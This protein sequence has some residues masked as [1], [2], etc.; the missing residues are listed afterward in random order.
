MTSPSSSLLLTNFRDLNRNN[1][2]FNQGD[3]GSMKRYARVADGAE[4]VAGN[5]SYWFSH[6]KCLNAQDQLVRFEGKG[7]ITRGAT[8]NIEWYFAGS[9]CEFKNYSVYGA[10]SLWNMDP[11]SGYEIGDFDL[12][13]LPGQ[14][15]LA[16]SY[17]LAISF[18][19]QDQTFLL[20]QISLINISIMTSSST[21]SLE[22]EKISASTLLLLI[23]AASVLIISILASAIV[24]AS[25]RSRHRKPA[26]GITSLQHLAPRKDETLDNYRT[27]IAQIQEIQ[28]SHEKAVGGE[29][30]S[31]TLSNQSRWNECNLCFTEMSK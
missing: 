10:V 7:F 4:F 19:Q 16:R 20:H 26:L 25:K 28:E 23:I 6:L 2:G 24:F 18:S 9:D 1:L 13:T 31:S 15:D 29:Q 5:G 17:A 14:N 30:D 8:I 11:G 21:A 12:S 3:D 27:N 22:A